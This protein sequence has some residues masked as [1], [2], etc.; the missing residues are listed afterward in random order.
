MKGTPRPLFRVFRLLPFLFVVVAALGSATPAYADP[1]G[2]NPRE[3]MERFARRASH[4]VPTVIDAIERPI[5]PYFIYLAWVVAGL[6]AVFSFLRLTRHHEGTTSDTVWWFVRFAVIMGFILGTN[7]VLSFL[8]GLGHGIAY[9]VDET[10]FLAR[11]VDEQ[12]DSFNASYNR[13][14][15]NQFVVKAEGVEFQVEGSDRTFDW[16]G[17]LSEDDGKL[18]DIL[19]KV[20][21]QSHSF[22]TL[23][24]TFS[25]SRTLMEFADLFLIVISY[26][27]MF[28]MRLSAPFML[29]LAIDRQIAGRI[30]NNYVWGVIVLTLVLPVVS[31]ITRIVVYAFGN[32]GMALGDGAP[33][34]QWDPAT[35]SVISSGNPW[36]TVSLASLVMLIGALC[37]FASPYISYKLCVGQVFE[38]VSQVTAGWFAAIASTGVEMFSTAGAAALNRQAENTTAQGQADSGRVEATANRDAQVQRI[39]GQAIMTRAA[40]NAQAH[41]TAVSAMAQAQAAATTYRNTAVGMNQQLD[42]IAGREIGEGKLGVMGATTHRHIENAEY[43]QNQVMQVRQGEAN[44]WA[45]VANANPVGLGG[46]AGPAGFGLSPT[47][48]YAATTTAGQQIEN[49]QGRMAV[50]DRAVRFHNET[51]VGFND[52][53]NTIITES[54]G[55]LQ[56]INTATAEQNAGAALRA[57]GATAGAAYAARDQAN[58]G[59]DTWKGMS[60]GAEQ[61][62]LDARVQAI[63]INLDAAKQA[64]ALRAQAAMVAQIGHSV[65]QRVDEMGDQL[66]Y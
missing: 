2:S 20:D 28:A 44:M 5:Y 7:D 38:A 57:G 47:G 63:D 60:I 49:A 30:F 27:L 35:L 66:R 25:V 16:L 29:A 41:V 3:I 36:Y 55:E 32:V 19:R 23:F 61:I 48:T 37:M 58:A 14:L 13:F 40:N 22:G 26:V 1:A 56:A 46:K 10:A 31:Q 51:D 64:A 4:L 43:S 8:G 53:R 6:V 12:E 33:L 59:V 65:A 45:G 21:P 39:E 54:K 17:V 52:Q 42:V 18:E 34:Y 15:E 24:S 11:L 62:V 9:G 50:H